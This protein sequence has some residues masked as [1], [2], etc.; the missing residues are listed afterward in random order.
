MT[1]LGFSPPS[2][3]ADRPAGAVADTSADPLTD[4]PAAATAGRAPGTAARRAKTAPTI[5]LGR[6]TRQALLVAHIVS[7]GAWVGIDVV[8][9]V[10]V[11]TGMLTDDTQVRGVAYQA[12]GM[13]ALWPLII[14][15]LLTLA[16]GILLGLGTKY[17]LVRFW[18][19]AVKLVLNV[20]LVGLVLVA[21]RPDIIKVADGGAE[22]LRGAD[23]VVETANLPFPPAVSLVVLT[24][25]IILS[26][27]KPWGRIRRQAR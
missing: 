25:A 1:S 21:L 20:V 9:G 23:V 24:T 27:F 7:V 5:P 10:L 16:T 4:A 17:G 2:T 8:L 26:V 12:L 22:I 19:V 15:G 13:F 18:W 14:A 3:P 11:F 6:R